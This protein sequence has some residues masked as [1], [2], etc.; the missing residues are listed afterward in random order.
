MPRVL[1]GTPLFTMPSLLPQRL[2]PRP[3]LRSWRAALVGTAL[4]AGA[5]LPGLG[6]A[7]VSGAEMPATGVPVSATPAKATPAAPTTAAPAPAEAILYKLATTC[8]L[9]GAAP[10]S[11]T[12]EAINQGAN[13]LYRH[14]IGS[15]IETIRITDDPVTMS[16]WKA[17][18]KEWRQLR[19]AAARFSTNTICFNDRDLCV[20]NPNYLNSVR[21]DDPTA[22]LKGRD[23]VRVHF[24][25]DGRVDASC[26]DAGCELVK[27]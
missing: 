8:S 22:R 25:P 2:S 26:Y 5:A 19:N 27:S 24:G 13:T 14:R 15:V 18:D 23:L 20:I 16:I 11:C 17:G 9:A 4:L 21:Q 12:V 6:A 7:P 10:V 3:Q 1:S